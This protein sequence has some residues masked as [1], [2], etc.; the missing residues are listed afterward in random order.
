MKGNRE[1]PYIL[2]MN[3]GGLRNN[4]NNNTPPLNIFGL[5]GAHPPNAVTLNGVNNVFDVPPVDAVLDVA[6][7]ING[8]GSLVK[9]GLG[10]MSLSQSNYYTG[11][12]TVS[13]GT[14][15]LSFPGLS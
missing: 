5:A 9:T 14:L 1:T 10:T 15:A 4:A 8:S 13:D 3:N 12:T 11:D 2:G 6:S 7:I